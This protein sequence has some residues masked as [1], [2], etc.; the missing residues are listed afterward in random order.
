MPWPGHQET[1]NLNLAGGPFILEGEAVGLK[2]IGTG[3]LLALVLVLNLGAQTPLELARNEKLAEQFVAE[4]ILLSIYKQLGLTVAVEP[5]PPARANIMTVT[6]EKGGEV[7]RIFS[8]GVKNPSLL[9]VEPAYYSLTTAA[10]AKAGRK[11][12]L[13]SLADLKKYR[14]GILLGVQHSKDAVEGVKDVSVA[15]DADSLFN[16]LNA[17]RF[18]IAL[19]TGI[20]GAYM[21]KKLK[22]TEIQQVAVLARLDLFHYLHEKNRQLLTRIADMI[23][24]LKANG[25]LAK[26]VAKAEQEFLSGRTAP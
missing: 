6:G 19:D 9:R 25:E 21:L 3:F 22:L 14:I 16:M 15:P 2:K 17:D 11:I 13:S 24:K 7:A 4:K 10:F 8:Y 26:L 18:D 20:N 12:T 23:K 5:L 1:K